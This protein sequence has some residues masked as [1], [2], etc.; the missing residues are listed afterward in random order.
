MREPGARGSVE[1]LDAICAAVLSIPE[2]YVATYGQVAEVAGLP[3]RAR[4]VGRALRHLPDESGIPWHRVVNAGGRIS[5][6]GT[7]RWERLQRQLLES[8]GVQFGPGGR[9]DLRAFGWNPA[10]D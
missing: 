6:R 3:R 8:E 7:P 5:P 4:L 1:A 2:G 10:G 9:I